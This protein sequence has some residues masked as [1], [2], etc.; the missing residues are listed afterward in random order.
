MKKQPTTTRASVPPTQPAPTPI[1]LGRVT[2]TG[3]IVELDEGFLEAVAHAAR[4]RTFAERVLSNLMFLN[5]IARARGNVLEYLKQCL[6]AG[7]IE[8]VERWASCGYALDELA[9]ATGE[10]I[11]KHWP[12]SSRQAFEPAPVMSDEDKAAEAAAAAEL[13]RERQRMREGKPAGDPVGGAPTLEQIAST[14][15]LQPPTREELE[16]DAQRRADEAAAES[17]EQATKKAAKKSARKPAA[18]PA[19]PA[20]PDLAGSLLE[21][22]AKRRKAA[23]STTRV[24]CMELHPNSKERCMHTQGHDVDEQ[25]QET[26]GGDQW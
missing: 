1:R 25:P 18:D 15:V 3:D 4:T 9:A 22:A 7:D 8:G 10:D 6:A 12:P 2:I 19:P 17:E 23:D 21:D 11:E 20:K 26:I 16:A 14:F 5:D 13:E 24:R